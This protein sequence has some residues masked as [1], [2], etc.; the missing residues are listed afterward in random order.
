MGIEHTDRVRDQ[1]IERVLWI[2]R[3]ELR[4]ATG[5]ALVEADD[6]VRAPQNV[7]DAAEVIRDSGPAVQQEDEIARRS[8]LVDCKAGANCVDELRWAGY[9]LDRSSMSSDAKD[10]VSARGRH[11]GNYVGM[12]YLRMAA[13]DRE[14]C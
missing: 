2:P 12:V 14:N 7:R 9:G 1:V 4:R 6:S 5:V 8:V 10:A 11:S 13:L 3:H